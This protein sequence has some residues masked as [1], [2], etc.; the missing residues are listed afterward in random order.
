MTAAIRA[1]N[2]P[3]GGG[4]ASLNSGKVA[5]FRPYLW[6]S[7][8]TILIA[9]LVSTSTI[10]AQTT[11]SN[12]PCKP[13]YIQR[14]PGGKCLIT[15]GLAN[16][17]CQ[18]RHG[19]R[20]LGITKT[21]RGYSCRYCK[22]GKVAKGDKCEELTIPAVVKPAW[23]EQPCKSRGKS[24]SEAERLKRCLQ[25][26]TDPIFKKP[27]N[28]WI[29]DDSVAKESG[30]VRSPDGRPV[31]YVYRP[32]LDVPDDHPLRS[33]WEPRKRDHR[34]VI[35][36]RKN[37]VLPIWAMCQEEY[38]D[39]C[40]GLI[41]A[42]GGY[43]FKL[44]KPGFIARG[45]VYERNPVKYPRRCESDKSIQAAARAKC[46]ENYGELGWII[47][48]PGRLRG[49]YPE[50][51]L[52]FC[53]KCAVG[54]MALVTGRRCVPK[55]TVEA[56]AAVKCREKY[57]DRC[58]GVVSTPTGFSYRF[59]KP[60]FIPHGAFRIC[61]PKNEEKNVAETPVKNTLPVKKTTKPVVVVST[62]PNESIL[63]GTLSFNVTNSGGKWLGRPI[64]M[65]G[66]VKI[67]VTGSKAF[68]EI[69]YKTNDLSLN[70][71][72]V[73][74]GS[75]SGYLTRGGKLVVAG[76]IP[77]QV[78]DM[79]RCEASTENARRHCRG[80][81]VVWLLGR[82]LGDHF[83]VK[84]QFDRKHNGTSRGEPM[85]TATLTPENFAAFDGD[86]LK[87]VGK[88]KSDIANEYELFRDALAA[89]IK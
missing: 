19:N 61:V 14:V 35:W 36:L 17:K 62:Q 26:K 2:V 4:V 11:A 56:D 71:I 42:K 87:R 22:P 9:F 20:L 49:S 45:L 54:S 73:A 34:D 7:L 37:V 69:S 52:Y 82:R 55:E 53:K 85:G 23:W 83:Q 31:P 41:K 66:S 80:T 29:K 43:R 18:G 24:E 30:E 40:R 65:R 8:T 5:V 47:R 89:F 70:Q 27:T 1:C 84:W 72:A 13:G 6:L 44:C 3:F 67:T 77:Y 57:G 64:R 48:I 39:R 25:A 46:S 79:A 28:S 68:A 16:A 86:V 21:L 38:P 50:G 74:R 12:G 60:G 76:R 33:K 10:F 51:Q 78:T 81:V 59:C 63:Q 58:I 75:I 88:L 15:L 32:E